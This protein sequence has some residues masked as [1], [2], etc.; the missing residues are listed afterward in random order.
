[1]DL[2]ITDM[3][4]LGSSGVLLIVIMWQ[5]AQIGKLIDDNKALTNRLFDLL[6]K[7]DRVIAQLD[8][9]QE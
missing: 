3:V 4:S 2:T 1:M 8:N 5:R 6:D 9:R 7:A